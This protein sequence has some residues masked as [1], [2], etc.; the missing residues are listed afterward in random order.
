VE[1]QSNTMRETLE[2]GDPM[3]L[4]ARTLGRSGMV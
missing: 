1:V 2:R 3:E 4:S